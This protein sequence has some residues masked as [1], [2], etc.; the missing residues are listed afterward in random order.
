M[1]KSLLTAVLIATVALSASDVSAR[2]S[3]RAGSE[4]RY[5][6]HDRYDRRDYRHDYRNRHHERRR[7]DKDE[8]KYLVGGMIV[9]AIIVDQADR[10][11]H[12]QYHPSYGPRYTRTCYDNVAY[13]SYGRAYVARRCYN[14]IR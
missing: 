12:S 14:R 10:Q 8:W 3:V 13:D 5:E 6:R 11:R 2:D 4:H 9:G 7:S 1:I